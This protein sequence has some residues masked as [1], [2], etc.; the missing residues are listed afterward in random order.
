MIIKT[1]PSGPFQT[2]AY[3]LGCPNTKEAAIVDPGVD[4][5]D[6]I[7][8]FLESHTLTPVKIILT[9][10]HWDHIGDVAALKKK[11]GIPVSIHELDASN[12]QNPGSDGLPMISPIE[13][14]V[15]DAFFDEDD[16][17]AIGEL[18]FVVIHTPGHTPGGVCFYCEAEGVLLSGDTLFKQSIGNLSF[19]TAQPDKMWDSLKKLEN[20]P[21]ATRVYPGHGSDTTI[22]EESWLPDARRIFQ[23]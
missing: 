15:P 13:G 5:A 11:Y 22:A 3:I 4:S 12:L 14:C 18:S 8:Q 6:S 7:I 16:K 9:H 1:L 10:S 17:I 19:P 20:L 2:N 23:G 21:P